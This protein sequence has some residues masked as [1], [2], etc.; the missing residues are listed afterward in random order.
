MINVYLVIIIAFLTVGAIRILK[1]AFRPNYF[2]LNQLVVDEYERTSI[3]GLMII[4]LPTFAGG[5]VVS[6][7]LG[8]QNRELVIFYGVMTSILIIWPV[9]LYSRSLLEERAYRRIKTVYFIYA[10]YAI[11][12]IWVAL[13]GSWTYMILTQNIIPNNMYINKFLAYYDNLH[14]LF[15]ALIASGIFA[16]LIWLTRKPIEYLKEKIYEQN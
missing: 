3:R 11:S 12:Q 7:I 16:T 6:A 13:W 9:I 10:L 4:Y 8:S 15:Q 5:S 2:S 1:I 14:T